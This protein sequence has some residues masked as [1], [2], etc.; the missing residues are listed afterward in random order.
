M[1]PRSKAMPRYAACGKP[2]WP[3]TSADFLFLEE[4]TVLYAGKSACAISSNT[5]VA[6]SSPCRV[7]NTPA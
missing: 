2:V 6:I 5:F 3:G 4:R 7:A 1:P